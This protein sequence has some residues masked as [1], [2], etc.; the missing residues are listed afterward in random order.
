MIHEK[1]IQDVDVSIVDDLNR[2]DFLF[3]NSTHVLKTGSDVHYEI[4]RLL[5]RV[6]SGVVIHFH[7]VPYPFEYPDKWIFQDNYS[8]NEAYAVRAFLMFNHEFRVLFWNSLFARR[9]SKLIKAEF[10]LFLRN[11]GGSIWIE[12]VAVS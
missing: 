4:F 11:P 6:K 3:I 2:N 8:W 9:F 7:D 1:E 10:P 12:R 5:P